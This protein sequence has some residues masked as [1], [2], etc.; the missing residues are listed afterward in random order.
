MI[1][2]RP[3]PEHYNPAMQRYVSLIQEVDILDVLESQLRRWLPA[4]AALPP[5]RAGFRYAAGKWTIREV[6]G[7][8]TDTERVFGYRALALARGETASLPPFDENVYAAAA[9]HDRCPFPELIDELSAL[10][11]SHVHLFRH[12]DDASWDRVGTAGGFA[13]TPRAM[14]YVM[15]GHVR[16]H[17]MVLAERY[18][19]DARDA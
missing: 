4:L 8:V 14:S 6:V 2:K 9:G 10:R 11:R 12:L 15:A 1:R 16:W 18:G 13:T 19:L 5:D 3:S 7:H 17:G